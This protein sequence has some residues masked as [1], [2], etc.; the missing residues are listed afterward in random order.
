MSLNLHMGTV[1]WHENNYRYQKKFLT[2]DLAEIEHF[3]FLHRLND[4]LAGYKITTAEGKQ[5]EWWDRKARAVWAT[6]P[7]HQVDL[8]NAWYKKNNK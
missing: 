2:T 6:S 5:I 4:N 1:Y 7:E 3:C 8:S